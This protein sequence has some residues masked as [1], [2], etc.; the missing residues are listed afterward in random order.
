MAEKKSY[1]STEF[2]VTI[3]GLIGG[4][5]LSLIPESPW[6]NVVGGVLS[7][8]ATGGYTAGRSLVKGKQEIAKSI[9]GK[10]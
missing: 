3:I 10:S 5:V 7:C 2:W 8:V 1:K 6:T 4:I 9:L